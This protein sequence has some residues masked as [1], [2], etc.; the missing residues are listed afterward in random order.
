MEN[1]AFVDQDMDQNGVK[2]N[3]N[4]K[5]SKTSKKQRSKKVYS[6]KLVE[7]NVELSALSKA[8]PNFNTGDGNDEANPSIGAAVRQ[9]RRSVI[10]K[11]IEKSKR[12]SSLDKLDDVGFSAL[13]HVTRYCRI[14]AIEDLLKSGANINLQSR[15]DDFT[16]LHIAAR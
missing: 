9:G 8:L 3:E 2:R 4:P 15:D 6:V 11:E 7:N 1:E 13:H 5:K 10:T 12:N 14:D 16:A